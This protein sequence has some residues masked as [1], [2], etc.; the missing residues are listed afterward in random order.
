MSSHDPNQPAGPN[1]FTAGP[2]PQPPKGSSGCKI[3]AIVLGIVV[4]L[5]LCCCGGC[6]GF[7][8]VVGDQSPAKEL[9]LEAIRTNSECVDRLGEP[10]EDEFI[11][12]NFNTTTTDADA[13]FPVSGPK[14]TAVVDCQAEK[15]GDDWVLTSGTVVFPDGTVV[16]LLAEP[17]PEVGDELP[18]LQLHEDPNEIPLGAAESTGEGADEAI[19]GEASSGETNP[20]RDLR[21]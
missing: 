1:P 5:P 2:T 17:E 7:I 9:A 10:I 12:S 6:L 15:R 3:V 14:G 16:D 19:E 4:L 20:S 18:D 8:W 11:N 21:N 13:H